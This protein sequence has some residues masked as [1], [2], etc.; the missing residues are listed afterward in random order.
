MLRQAYFPSVFI[1]FQADHDQGQSPQSRTPVSRRGLGFLFADAAVAPR[2]RP[3]RRPD[4]AALRLVST[5]SRRYASA[6]LSECQ[7][8]PATLVRR[9]CDETVDIAA[10]LLIRSNALSDI[11]LIALIGRHGLG[12]ARAIGRRPE[13]NPTIAKLVAVLGRKAV[14]MRPAD[15][16]R[17]ADPRQ[18]NARPAPTQSP[19]DADTEAGPHGA[20]AE[21][22]RRR[23][24]SMMR[25]SEA[26]ESATSSPFVARSVYSRLRDTVLTGN[27]ALISHRARQL[28]RHRFR[29]C[30]QD[31]RHVF[32]HLAAGR[33]ARA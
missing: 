17:T 6:A 31:G 30:E 10:P 27:P 12:H 28:P 13:L 33:I 19:G 29:H 3:A 8:P 7:Y 26:S 4:P 1:R 22:A 23:L 2:D 16:M 5:E 15:R 20:A 18:E 9:L 25:P 11:D 32:I 14:Q 21:N 24:R